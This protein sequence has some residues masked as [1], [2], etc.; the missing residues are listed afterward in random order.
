[1]NKTSSSEEH[2]NLS[3]A[4]TKHVQLKTLVSSKN[5]LSALNQQ[6]KTNE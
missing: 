1:M 4:A 2:T 3:N 6:K 5:S